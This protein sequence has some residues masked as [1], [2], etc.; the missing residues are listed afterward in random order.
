MFAREHACGLDSQLITTR[1]D[2]TTTWTW[3]KM[4]LGSEERSVFCVPFFGDGVFK[5]HLSSQNGGFAE[6][7]SGPLPVRCRGVSGIEGLYHLTLTY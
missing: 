4:I 2:A 6:G 1:D 3:S 5:G 7:F